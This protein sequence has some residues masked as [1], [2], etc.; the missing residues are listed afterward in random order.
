MPERK[1]ETKPSPSPA[2]A[3]GRHHGGSGGSVP[4]SSNHSE[5][6]TGEGT[7]SENPVAVGGPTEEGEGEEEE[8]NGDFERRPAGKNEMKLVSTEDLA[9]KTF[10]G[11]DLP[12]PLDTLFGS[13]QAAWSVLCWGEGGSGKSTLAALTGHAM[14]PYAAAQDGIVLYVGAEEGA[15][16]TQQQRTKRL[17]AKAENYH[18]TEFTT[19]EELK[20]TVKAEN[21]RFLVMDSVSDVDPRANWY[22]EF[23]NWCEDRGTG[24]FTICHALKNGQS[25]KGNSGLRHYHEIIVR[26][27]QDVDDSH[28]AKTEKNRYKPLASVEIPMTGEQRGPLKGGDMIEATLSEEQAGNNMVFPPDGLPTERHLEAYRINPVRTPFEITLGEIIENNGNAARS[29][30]YLNSYV[31]NRRACLAR[32]HSGERADAFISF[33]YERFGKTSSRSE[34]V[35]IVRMYFDDVLE[36]EWCERT[37][38][39]CIKRIKEEY[40]DLEIEIHEQDHAKKVLGA[41]KYEQQAEAFEQARKEEE[42]RREAQKSRF[43]VTGEEWPRERATTGAGERAK[44]AYRIVENGV[45]DRYRA[46]VVSLSDGTLEGEVRR[47][48]AGEGAGEEYTVVEG[49]DVPQPVQEELTGLLAETREKRDRQTTEAGPSREEKL[50]A[51]Y[52]EIERFYDAL[53]RSYEAGYSKTSIRTLR[54]ALSMAS[55]T[56]SGSET[57]AIK[58][59][60][61]GKRADR[62][63]FVP[64]GA[65]HT[66]HSEAV[67]YGGRAPA[68]ST[69]KLALKIAGWHEEIQERGGADEVAAT[70]D[71]LVG[72][73]RAANARAETYLVQGADAGLAEAYGLD[74]SAAKEEEQ[75]EEEAQTRRSDMPKDPLETPIP[76]RDLHEVFERDFGVQDQRLENIENEERS[77]NEMRK[78]ARKM[79]EARLGL[80]DPREAIQLR[81]LVGKGSA[82]GSAERQYDVVDGNT[83]VAV[84]RKWGWD[85]VPFDEAER[86]RIE[87]VSKEREKP[88]SSEDEP[89]EPQ[90]EPEPEPEQ[91]QQQ[92]TTTTTV[93]GEQVGEESD[94]FMQQMAAINQKMEEMAGSD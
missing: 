93:A 94:P 84:A 64:T 18:V 15:S 43:E 11:I 72:I 10:Y 5:E 70:D 36:K 58:R 52:H 63:W 77:E 67:G 69:Q 88:G 41:E 19:R 54:R 92:Q 51:F 90:P 55:D 56:S 80:R 39:E 24:V 82:E 53:K 61:A 48:E 74:A 49:D 13:P 32:R 59:P 26:C 73:E 21:V 20:Q 14:T 12:V 83:T 87:D 68:V 91:Q 75:Q 7:P 79:H 85:F 29:I 76:E 17:D 50:R 28:W 33:T 35:V 31:G 65:V 22:F 62:A 71:V 40:G 2:A 6:G 9:E 16:L 46:T 57:P 8:E 3:N 23:L 47:M 1:Q 86:V 44:Y 81:Y 37:A 30:S 4:P 25:F 42:E 78:A 45:G 27:Y 60:G 34:P 38:K 89:T 66:I